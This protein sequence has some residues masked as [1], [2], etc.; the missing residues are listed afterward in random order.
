MNY[1]GDDRIRRW[2]LLNKYPIPTDAELQRFPIEFRSYD[3]VDRDERLRMGLALGAWITKLMYFSM[4]APFW[5]S[6]L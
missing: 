1:V 6:E 2:C 4:R 3:G 5:V